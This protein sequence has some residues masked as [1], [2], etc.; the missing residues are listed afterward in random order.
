MSDANRL[1]KVEAQMNAMAHAWLTL[2]AALEAESGFDAAGLQR[3]LLQRRWPQRPDL[4][5]EARESLRWL[6]DQLDESRA[7]RQTPAH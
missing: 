7:T 2:V 6:C 1:L 4:N 3:S 5:T